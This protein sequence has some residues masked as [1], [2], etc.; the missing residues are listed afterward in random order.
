M[1]NFEF[2]WNAKDNY[3]TI[4]SRYSEILNSELEGYSVL[5]YLSSHDD[6]AP[7]DAKREK[8]IES[9]TK[10]LLSPGMAQI[11]YGDE[12]ARPLVIE[13]TQG[14]ATLRSF[15]NWDEIQSNPQTKKILAHWQKLGRFRQ[16]HPAVG[17]GIHKQIS[18]APYTFSRGLKVGKFLD[19]VVVGLDMKKGRKELNVSSVF[20]EGLILRDAYSGQSTTVI[21]GK[22]VIDSDFDIV[23]LELKK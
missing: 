14:D 13:G 1:I 12:S 20:K 23:M 15:M 6:G 18:S 2:K 8:S 7:F 11:Y 5:N 4:F 17:A 22:A 16:S 9:A 10:L 3:E 19:R 21:N